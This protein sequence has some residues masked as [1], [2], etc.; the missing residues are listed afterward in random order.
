MEATYHSVGTLGTVVKMS[1]VC[2]SGEVRGTTVAGRDPGRPVR[3]SK[4]MKAWVY[5]D[6]PPGAPMEKVR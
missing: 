4:S 6:T 3:Y 1:D 2:T 5:A